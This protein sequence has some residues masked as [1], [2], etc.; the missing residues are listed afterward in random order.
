MCRLI[1]A[2]TIFMAGKKD[3]NMDAKM[4]D[5]ILYLLLFTIFH[6]E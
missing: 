4:I 2:E 6:K 1:I 3:F 5:V